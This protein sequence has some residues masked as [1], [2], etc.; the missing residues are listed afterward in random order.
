MANTVR[1]MPPAFAPLQSFLDPPQKSSNSSLFVITNRQ[2]T[3][4]AATIFYPGM[5]EKIAE[6]VG[7]SY[8]VLPSSVHELIIV[9]DTGDYDYRF[10]EKTV[11][12]INSDPVRISPDEKLSDNVYY[13][14]RKAKAFDF[15]RNFA[16]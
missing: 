11:S 5:M 3:L 9:P 13:F 6:M 4:G 14:D 7:S 10:L 2:K 16:K 8:F 12:T 15:A 1:L